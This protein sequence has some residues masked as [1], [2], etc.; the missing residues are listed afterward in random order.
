MSTSYVERS[1]IALSA[2]V[3]IFAVATRVH[4][5]VAFPALHDFDAPGHALNV[6]DLFEGHLPNPRSWS[7][8]Q[9]PL[10]YGIGAALW[11]LLPD[12]VPVHVTLRLISVVSWLAA[13]GLVWRV[14][15]RIG[16]EVDAAVVAAL[17]LGV[18]G[19]LIGSCMMTN[20]ALCALFVT[21]TVVR[22]LDAPSDDP[23]TPGHAALTGVFAGLASL[24]KSTG[25]AAVGVAAAWYAWQSR[26]STLSAVRNLFIL[27]LVAGGIGAPHYARMFFALP[28]SL[29]DI[30]AVRAGSQE[31]EAAVAA[32]LARMPAERLRP[33]IPALVH[34][35]VWGDP[36][37]VFLPLAQPGVKL[38][39]LVLLAAGLGVSA[40]AMVG[41]ARLV[42]RREI[43]LRVWPGL[44]LGVFLAVSL[45]P[46]AWSVPFFV[47]TKPT[48]VLPAVLPVGLV[49]S[50]GVEAAGRGVRGTVLRGLLLA[51]AAGGT[52]LTW[53]GW[54]A[55]GSTA[56]APIA[57]GAAPKGSPVQAVERYFRY[58]A[59]DPIRAGS[60]L[61][62][63]LQLAHGLR[64]AQILQLPVAP[65]PWPLSPADERALELARAQVAWMDLYHLVRWLQPVASALAV[66]LIDAHESTDDARVRVRVRAAVGTSPW[67]VTW[68]GAW[69]FDQFDQDFTLRRAGD[70]WRITAIAQGGVSDENMGPAFVAYPTLAGLQRLRS[71]GWR[72]SWEGPTSPR[73]AADVE[74]GA[75]PNASP[76]GRPEVGQ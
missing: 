59:D 33:W 37:G 43:V 21:A 73:A 47:A 6:V 10:Y 76:Q 28:G 20:D 2:A 50:F 38:A 65:E 44:A 29:Y 62:A 57:F 25:L 74:R 17:L 35:G 31:K 58:R 52:A 27:G 22:L 16:S 40:V 64:I 3:V 36:V 71:L 4:D 63:E 12:A 19:I 41:A 70:G 69:P 60:L 26:R 46:H 8:G 34:V 53:Y 14:L 9:P 30:L 45:L 55:P 66:S 42:A 51:V 67:G 48:Y 18:P 54:W 23:P 11:A 72:P 15:R 13:V 68:A 32:L 7:G 61:S 24:T 39:M 49:L 1:I 5:V 75:V 56:P